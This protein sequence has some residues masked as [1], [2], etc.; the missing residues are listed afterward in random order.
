MHWQKNMTVCKAV[1]TSAYQAYISVEAD[2]GQSAGIHVLQSAADGSAVAGLADADGH[3]LSLEQLENRV[4]GGSSA[5][6]FSCCTACSRSCSSARSASSGFGTASPCVAKAGIEVPEASET[7]NADTMA[8]QPEDTDINV[9]DFSG[10]ETA[11]MVSAFSV[12]DASGTSMPALATILDKSFSITR[13]SCI[14]SVW[15]K[16]RYHGR[17]AGGYRHKCSR[18]FR[19]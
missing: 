17:T 12:S 14:F 2:G 5:A 8:G 10:Y 11:A 7:E 4:A 19:L 16:C 3:A 9:A 15:G 18:F 1:L 13:K 6:A